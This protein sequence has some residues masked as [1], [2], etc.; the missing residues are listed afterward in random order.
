MVKL[1]K[2]GV[3]YTEGKLLKES[4]AFMVEAKK[5]KAIKGT[6]AYNILSAHNVGDEENLKIKFDA[7]A[8]HDITYVG[9]IQTAKAS[10]LEKFPLS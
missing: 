3:Y 1:I 7:M 10:G 6:I 5:Q 9:I 2:G 8:S 4:V